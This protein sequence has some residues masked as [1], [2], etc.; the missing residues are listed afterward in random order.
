MKFNQTSWF[1]SSKV[2]PVMPPTSAWPDPADDNS[3]FCLPGG[4]EAAEIC[5]PSHEEGTRTPNPPPSPGGP[6]VDDTPSP[7]GPWLMTCQALGPGL[8]PSRRELPLQAKEIWRFT[9][10]TSLR[11]TSASELWGSLS[12]HPE[13]ALRV[14]QCNER[15]STQPA[16]GWGWSG[17]WLSCPL[18]PVGPRTS[19]HHHLLTFSQG[20]R[21]L[22]A[23]PLWSSPSWLWLWPSISSCSSVRAP[24]AQQAL[25]P[26]L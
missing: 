14:S 25:N 6:W 19:P 8:S 12:S 5:S 13:V 2:P 17:P 21:S 16:T 24:P 3:S 20:S 11:R 18:G 10:R 15:G 1:P 4:V 23:W 22:S 26:R 9:K 7:G